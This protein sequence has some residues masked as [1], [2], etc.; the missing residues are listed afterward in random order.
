MNTIEINTEA[1]IDANKQVGP[2]VNR[3]QMFGDDCKKSKFDD[4]RNL[5]T[6]AI[7]VM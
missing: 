6:D 4:S 3:A 1:L 7:L 2:E 5:R